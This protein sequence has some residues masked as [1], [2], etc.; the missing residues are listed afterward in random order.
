M[1]LLLLLIL[2]LLF[3]LLSPSSG[4]ISI[5]IL[6]YCWNLHC[7]TTGN[8]RF[9]SVDGILSVHASTWLKI[10]MMRKCCSS[11][12]QVKGL[13]SRCYKCTILSN[14]KKCKMSLYNILNTNHHIVW[15][16]PTV[17]LHHVSW[18]AFLGK[19]LIINKIYQE[20][21]LGLLLFLLHT[22]PLADVICKHYMSYHLY[23]ED[24]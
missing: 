16:G 21:V 1:L 15:H 10:Q 23:A 24:T 5:I 12:E 13:Y 8:N 17:P 9:T 6:C 4:F 19:K 3:S 20:S 2:I 7:C 14:A 18:A 22:A 11:P